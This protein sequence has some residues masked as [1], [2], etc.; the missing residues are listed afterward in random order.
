M[1]LVIPP[2]DG[3][4]P[5]Y[6]CTSLTSLFWGVDVIFKPSNVVWELVNINEYHL[7]LLKH[8]HTFLT[9]FFWQRRS[10]SNLQMLL[11]PYGHQ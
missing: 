4:T 10:F 1:F 7:V 2:K 6:I 3:L 5:K 11:G 8:I 9:S